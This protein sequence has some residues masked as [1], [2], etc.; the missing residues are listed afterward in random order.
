LGE[1]GIW[2]SAK[3][4]TVTKKNQGRWEVLSRFQDEWERLRAAREILQEDF[5]GRIDEDLSRQETKIK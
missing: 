1:S 2:T 4:L 3:L 5:W